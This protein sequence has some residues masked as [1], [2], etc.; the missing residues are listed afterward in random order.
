MEWTCEGTRASRACNIYTTDC[1]RYCSCA[2]PAAWRRR[3]W[4]LQDGFNLSPS[5]WIS[6]VRIGRERKGITCKSKPPKVVSLG[7]SAED[8]SLS[9]CPLGKWQWG[10][11]GG[12]GIFLPT[13]H[14]CFDQISVDTSAATAQLGNVM[15]NILQTWFCCKQVEQN[16]CHDDV[17]C[18]ISSCTTSPTACL[19]EQ[20][21]WGLKACCL[22]PAGLWWADHC[23]LLWVL[24]YRTDVRQVLAFIPLSGKGH[25]MEFWEQCLVSITFWIL[26]KRSCQAVLKEKYGS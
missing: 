15:P 26:H 7:H 10:T 12:N 20:C 17:A 13:K 11:K 19:W 21:F 8:G 4:L 18:G 3:Q 25:C 9:L 16:L 22:R 5:F 14:I 1:Q 23:C 2:K 24:C 6:S